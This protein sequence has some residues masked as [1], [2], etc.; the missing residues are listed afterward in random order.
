VDRRTI[1]AYILIVVISI[2]FFSYQRATRRP[3]PG[4]PP[5]EIA[6]TAASAPPSGAVAGTSAPLGLPSGLPAAKAGEPAPPA[7]EAGPQPALNDDIRLPGTGLKYEMRWSNEGAC[8]REARLTDYRQRRNKP[9]GV[10][11]LDATA[12]GPATL[13]LQDAV[14]KLPL[15]SRNYELLEKSDRRLV[16]ATTFANDLRVTKEYVA[17]PGKYDLGMKVTLK[18]TSAQPLDVQYAIVAAGR[19]VPE[20]GLSTEVYGAIGRRRSPES[21]SID[22]KFPSSVKV[23]FEPVNEPD[24]MILYAGACS[25]YFAAILLPKPKSGDSTL[26]FVASASVEL[27]PK[28]DAI[29][30]VG[31]SISMADNVTVKLTTVKRTL[32]PGEEVSD[33]YTYFLGPMDQKVLAQYPDI[34][35]VLDNNYGIFGFMSKIL[36]AVLRGI[37]RVI[38]NYGVAII[39]LTILVRL[40]VFPLTRKGQIAMAR[41]QKLQ[42]L[43][44]G[45]QEKYKD[46]RQRQGREMME[47]YRKH[48]ANPMSGCWPVLLQIPV[49]WGLYRML[50]FSIDLRQQP[51]VSWIS[52]L[53]RPDT[54]TAI[55]GIPLNVLPVLMTVSSL[56]QQFTMPKPADPQQAQTQKMMMFM[57]VLMLVWF[58]SLP[59]GLTLYWLTSTTSGII[60]QRIIKLQIK[61][62]EAHGAFAPEEAESERGNRQKFKR[63]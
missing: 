49:L 18:N 35:R 24:R 6:A 3:P 11:L 57:P 25:R 30:S 2:L 44:K 16:F 27:L 40:C 53:S 17:A 38:P 46:D 60:E 51:F 54:I 23:P 21:I 47:L 43:I 5:S 7:V 34:A 4:S 9:E 37:F 20:L 15:D 48:N 14:D 59:S 42:P 36:L 39:L 56:V 31:G 55:S 63:R 22:Q 19:L 52:D 62:M 26:D 61:R 45:L 33:E 41:M 13:A 58:Y 1:I 8:L 32:K 12:N 50:M 29:Q 10:L 28:C